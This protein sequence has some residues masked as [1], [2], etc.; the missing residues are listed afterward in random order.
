MTVGI[1]RRSEFLFIFD[2]RMANPNG[3]PD[4]NRPRIDPYSGKNLVTEYRL[5]RTVRDYLKNQGETIFIREDLNSDGS[6]KTI[7]ELAK[8][9]IKGEK[10]EKEVDRDKLIKEHID[11]R[12]FGL[13]F[14]VPDATFK[15]I[16]PVQFSIG[17]S[18]NKV[19][20]IIVRNTRIVPTKQGAEAGTFG[21]K[22]IIRYSLIVF[23]GFLNQIAAKDSNLSEMDIEKMMLA[24]W[25]GTN[26]LSTSSKFGQTS[27]FLL[28]LIYAD[29]KAYLGDIDRGV[30]IAHSENIEDISQAGIDLTQMFSMLT[31][32]KRK[33]AEIQFGCHDNM[34]ANGTDNLKTLI[35][36]WAE[37][38]GIEYR[39]ILGN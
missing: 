24:M 27:R 2:T 17:Q 31:E 30:S 28:R 3:D 22:T 16:G 29:D 10:K 36:K 35:V 5:K 23:H 38:N 39:N 6:R 32:N 33:I 34:F 4:E 1:A 18:L 15:S 25:H 21:E 20:E 14:A 37:G 9:Y 13:L 19:Q 7:E 8:P 12:L 11:V 26:N